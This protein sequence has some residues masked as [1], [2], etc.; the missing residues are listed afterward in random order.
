VKVL[1]VTPSYRPI[2][3]GTETYVHQ[4][5]VKLNDAGISTD[6]MTL[7][8]DEKWK[9]TSRDEIRFDDGFKLYRVSASNPRALNFRGHT[10]SA[11]L[12]NVH[13]VPR[14][15][16]SSE[17]GEYDIIHFH[18]DIDLSF[19]FF[20][21]FSRSKTPTLL[22]CHS[23]PYTYRRYRRNILSGTS[24]RNAADL[25]VGLSK[26][27]IGLLQNLGVPDSKL[28]RL[29][30]AV[31]VKTFHPD[32]Q[33]KMDNVVL[34]AARITKG[35]GLDVLLKA[36]LYLDVETRLVIIG[37]IGDQVFFDEIRRLALKINAETFHKVEY[38][39]VVGASDLEKWYRRASIFVCPS[40]SDHF[41][42]SILEAL[43]SGTPVVATRIAAIPE[44]VVDEFNGLLVSENQPRALALALK[45]LLENRRFRDE[46]GNNARHIA[47]E[48]FS[49][50]VVLRKLTGT[51]EALCG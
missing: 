20:A 8:M 3:G 45:R 33:E 25:Y 23:I 17:F 41:P 12:L 31:D 43:A 22:H 38:R 27:S 26:F 48:Y 18:D 7:N 49:W 16:F 37:P 40:V 24:F 9:P 1:M 42:I 35:K 28:F 11:E 10:L 50:D 46:V 47:E 29:P 4:L 13:V 36:L 19:P 51:Y 5:T 2:V 6:V 39:G 14:L 34:Y 44:I 21:H 15:N 30:N 32:V